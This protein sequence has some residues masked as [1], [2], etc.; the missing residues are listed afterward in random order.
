MVRYNWIEGGNRQLD[1]VDAEDSSALRA[2]PSYRETRVYGNVLIEPPG[3]GNSQIVHYGGD[4]GKLDW[5]RKGTLYFFHN[6]VVSTRTDRT[7]LFRLSTNDES[8]D[9]RNNVF[10]TV[11]SGATLSVLNA[12]GEIALSHNWIKP[13]WREAFT[14]LEGHIGK[15]GMVESDAPGFRDEGGQDYRPGAKSAMRMRGAEVPLK[16]DRQYRRHQGSDRP[17]GR[18]G[19]GRVRAVVGRRRAHRAWLRALR[20]RP[21]SRSMAGRTPR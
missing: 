9:A 7:T 10:Y 17:Q 4:S 2:D 20:S 19:T 1:L 3:D 12:A 18:A 8:C 5:Y 13:G 6:T 21:A 15:D 11:G 14:D 16:L